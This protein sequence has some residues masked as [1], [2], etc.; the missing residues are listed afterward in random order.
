MYDVSNH[1]GIRINKGM[2][3]F[4]ILSLFKFIETKQ[5]LWFDHNSTKCHALVLPIVRFHSFPF[6]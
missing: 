6:K 1:V 5:I 4:I 2:Y 3:E